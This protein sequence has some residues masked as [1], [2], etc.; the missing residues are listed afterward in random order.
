[1]SNYYNPD[2]KAFPDYILKTTGT[3]S[4]LFNLKDDYPFFFVQLGLQKALTCFNY[5][6]INP[7]YFNDFYDFPDKNPKLGTVD[8]VAFRDVIRNGRWYGPY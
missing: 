3:N 7:L 6:P 5:N 1:M 4:T 8:K 2:R